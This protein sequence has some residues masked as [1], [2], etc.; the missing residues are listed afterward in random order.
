MFDHEETFRLLL[1]GRRVVIW[2]W[3]LD[4]RA[5]YQAIQA[6]ADIAVAGP[7]LPTATSL[8]HYVRQVNPSQLIRRVLARARPCGRLSLRP[9]AGFPDLRL[10]WRHR[11]SRCFSGRL[12]AH[13]FTGAS[14]VR[15]TGLYK[16]V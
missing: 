5:V 11:R 14:H 4:Y 2:T 6:D 12:L 7:E 3:Q 15:I 10:L 1:Q 9:V 16:T 13:C 8:S